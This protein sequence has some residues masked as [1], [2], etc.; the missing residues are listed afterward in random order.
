M[1][2]AYTRPRYQVSVYRTIGPL[3]IFKGFLT[4]QDCLPLHWGY[5]KT[6]QEPLTR[7][8]IIW[9]IYDSGKQKN[10]PGIICVTW[11]PTYMVK[12]FQISHK[13]KGHWP[14]SL[15]RRGLYSI[16]LRSHLLKT[17]SRPTDGVN[18]LRSIFLPRAARLTR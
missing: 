18:K 6:S 1:F 9:N 4:S 17:D 8:Q 2:C 12:T 11:P 7:S 14:C 15:E 5:S 10:F 16:L 13:P 3:V